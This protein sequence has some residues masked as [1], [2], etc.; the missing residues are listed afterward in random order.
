M[1]KRLKDGIQRIG[2]L[3]SLVLELLQMVGSCSGPNR[4]TLMDELEEVN[5]LMIS[6]EEKTQ[7]TGKP[8]S[9]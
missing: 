7:S 8:S 4:Q 1:R 6:S 9:E 5:R 3:V 2:Q